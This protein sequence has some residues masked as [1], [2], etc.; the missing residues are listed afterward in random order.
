MRKTVQKRFTRTAAV[1]VALT[2][3]LSVFGPVGTVAAQEVSVSQSEDAVTAAPGETVTLT[4]TMTATDL[5]GPGVQVQLPTGWVGTIEDAGGGSPKA[6]AGGNVLRVVFLTSG[7][8]AVT[9]EVQVPEDAA[10]GDYTVDVE[11]SGINPSDSSRITE[12][13]QTTITVAE[14]DQNED[15][16]A[17]FTY[18]PDSPEAGQQVSFDASGSSDD[19]S[20][21]NYEW[22]LD[23]DGTTDATGASVAHTFDAAGSYDVELTVTDD[24]GATATATQTVSVSAAPDPA[25]FQVSNLDVAS[26]VTQG[27]TTSVSATIENTGDE[28]ATQ[29][30][31]FAVDGEVVDSQDVTL[32]GGASQQVSFDLDTAGVQTGDHDVSISTDDDDAT[33]TVTVTAAAVDKSSTVSLSPSSQSV[34]SGETTT[35]DLVVDDADGGVGAFEASI[36]LDSD[37]ATITDVSVNNGPGQDTH[38]VI[39]SDGSSVS[40]KAAFQDTADTGSVSIA[41]IT[42][43][44]ESAGEVGLSIGPATGEDEV[45]IFDE[46]GIG[47]DVTGTND[48]TL[49]VNAL[50]ALSDEFAG[51]PQDL[52][53]DG[54]YEDVN[55]DGDVN[56]GDA[57]ALFAFEDS[58]TVQ[59][60][61]ALFDINEDGDVNVGDA[62]ALFAQVTA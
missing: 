16:T 12:S 60:H 40:I 42:V 5:N 10:E 34:I 53:G 39:D 54:L 9:Y 3:V 33:G 4:T 38:M 31:E 18:S 27:E 57:Q 36:A 15:P 32:A 8:Y 48:A 13:T 45:L 17:S 62:Q 50:P 46:Q 1:V 41:T 25:N 49:T 2:V 35:F 6:E 14:P 7:T 55:G 20:I 47:Y 22:D 23:G 29:T 24:D 43:A 30:V 44:G 51:P 58:A 61:A 19:S 52:D 56:V 28:E 21:A 26:S 59:E 37:A 11:G